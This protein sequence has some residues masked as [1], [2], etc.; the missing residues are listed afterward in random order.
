MRGYAMSREKSIMKNYLFNLVKTLTGLLFPVITFAYSSRI[1][2]VEG[3]GKVNFSK[4]YITYFAMIALLGMNYYGTREAAKIRDNKK[5]LSKFVQE[6]LMINGIATSIAYIM[7]IISVLLIPKLRNYEILLAVNSISIVLQGLGMEWLYQ[8]L[9]EYQYIAV[10]SVIF[11]VIALA[12]MFICVKDSGDVVSY[13]VIYVFAT[14]GSYILNFINARKYIEWHWFGGYAC[15]KHFKALFLLFAM[16]VSIQ[17]YVVLDSTML[18]F[19]KGDIAVGKYTAAVKVNKMAT[20]LITALGVVL[21]PRL[22]YYIGNHQADK[23]KKLIDKAYNFVFCLSVPI[24]IGLFLLSDDILLLFSGKEFLTASVTMKLLSPIVIL[25]PFNV[26]TNTQTFVPMG[27]EKLIL[28]STFSGAVTNIVFNLALIPLYA[29][30][31]AA[32]ATVLSEAVVAVICYINA[33]RYFP[34]KEIFRVYYQYWIAAMP[35]PLIVSVIKRAD[36]NCWIQLAASIGLSAVTYF[37]L[38]ILFRNYYVFE[39][40]KKLRKDRY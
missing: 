40:A 36:I 27:K 9:E 20:S 39:M 7:L 11:Q 5:L 12:L 22:S 13:A 8:A 16:A 30:N 1:L 34:M 10:R 38:L 32:I 29:E 15:R 35:I 4:S 21:I 24:C 6:M 26:V 3:I 23:L 14:Y 2:G 19:I 28:I 25:I 37:I 33:R 18:G 17:L 31:G